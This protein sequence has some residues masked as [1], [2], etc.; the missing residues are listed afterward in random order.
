MRHD[1]HLLG[2]GLPDRRLRH[3]RQHRL[4]LC[5]RRVHS[6][7]QAPA[8]RDR[9]GLRSQADRQEQHPWLGLRSPRPSRRRR[10]YLRRGDGAAGKSR[11]QEGSAAAEAAVSG[12]RRALWLPDHGQQRRDHRAGARH[13][14]PRR[15]VVRLDR[16]RQQHR[17]QALL[18]L[19]PRR[20][21]VQRGRGHGHS[22]ARADREACRRR[23]RR[24]GQSARP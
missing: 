3:G 19:R 16:T 20:A 8:G 4:H 18:H 15:G 10:L 17:H 23:A 9:P 11:G 7:A 1:P 21:D 6:R 24:L 12:E 14:A 5:A 13:H 22:A 2:R